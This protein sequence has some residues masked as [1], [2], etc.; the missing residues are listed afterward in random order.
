MALETLQVP[1][2]GVEVIVDPAFE[3]IDFSVLPGEKLAIS[4][5]VETCE[6]NPDRMHQASG[7]LRIVGFSFDGSKVYVL[8]WQEN[9][10]AE[11]VFWQV[12]DRCIQAKAQWV[13][14]NSGFDIPYLFPAL[15]DNGLLHGD[16]K[17][18]LAF[19]PGCLKD[20]RL[21]ER[22]LYANWYSAFSLKAIVARRFD[23]VLAKETR[24]EFVNMKLA[25]PL[26]QEQIEYAALDVAYTRRV[27]SEQRQEI[28][29]GGEMLKSAIFV[30]AK[31]QWSTFHFADAPVSEKLWSNNA[32]TVLAELSIAE[33]RVP[34]NVRSPRQ[35]MKWLQQE[36]IPAKSSSAKELK[37]LASRYPQIKDLLE[38]RRLTKLATSYGEGWLERFVQDGH[39]RPSYNVFGADTSRWSSSN[40]N[41]QQIP[42]GDYRKMFVAPE[43]YSWVIADYSQ[44]EVWIAAYMAGDQRMIDLLR[45]G[46][47]YTEVGKLIYRDPAMQKSDKRRQLAKS[48]VLGLLY[49]LT[50]GGMAKNQNIDKKAAKAVFDGI[51]RE[52]PALWR[53]IHDHAEAAK[54]GSVST[55]LGHRYWLNLFAWNWRNNAANSPVQGTGSDMVKLAVSDYT[56]QRPYEIA[57]VVH[58]E[59]AAIVPDYEAK[60]A[61]VLLERCMGLAFDICLPGLNVVRPAVAHIGKSWADKE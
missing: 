48:A 17:Q 39:V 11:T 33:R 40:P 1:G 51:K 38:V 20:T 10:R 42:R 15:C 46:D 60:E 54:N 53:F 59:I 18:V 43:G 7:F 56:I 8:R 25:D 22:A 41:L 6:D 14:H 50:P 3:D 35:V 30:D 13:I 27:Y 57:L 21:I 58:D 16:G 44:Q 61:A 24:D 55:R 37:N 47:V 19:G 23:V 26:T 2:H 34:V 28:L 52:F 4:V 12:A 31:A 49:G 9:P 32:K 45:T 36:G 5:D 29:R